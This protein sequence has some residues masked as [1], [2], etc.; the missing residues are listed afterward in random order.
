MSGKRI[1]SESGG[2]NSILS[3]HSV[4]FIDVLRRSWLAILAV[5]V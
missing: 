4:T 3:Y 5:T 1:E 2:M